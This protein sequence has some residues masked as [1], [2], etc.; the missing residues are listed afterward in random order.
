[1]SEWYYSSNGQQQGPISFEQLVDISKKGGLHPTKDLVWTA[2]MKDWT[3]AGN[4]PELSQASSA[5]VTPPVADPANPYATPSSSWN[6]TPAPTVGE[7]LEEIPPGSDPI[8]IGACLKAGFELT[9]KHFITILLVG[10][11]Y[12]GVSILTSIVFSAIDQAMGYG[13]TTTEL[14][15]FNENTS[16]YYTQSGGPV[17]IIGSNLVSIFLSLG[18]ARIGLNLVSGKP[19]DVGMLFGGGSKMLRATG[20]TLL[21]GAMTVL[22]F[23]LLIVPGFYVILRFGQYLTA[24]VD[25]DLGIMESFSYSSSITTNNKWRLLGLILLSILLILAGVMAC[26]IG[27]IFTAPIAWLAWMTAYRWMQFG[28]RAAQNTP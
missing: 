17:G 20:A 23:A 22:G 15:R 10:I 28:N 16:A 27:L 19:A 1:M 8:V 26:G 18:L 4:V 12:F 14:K 7:S 5:P 11:T 2:S 21:F 3:P 9:K 6:S 25:R 24:I 13:T